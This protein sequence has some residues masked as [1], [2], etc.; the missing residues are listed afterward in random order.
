MGGEQTS[1]K[2]MKRPFATSATLSVCPK[3]AECSLSLLCHRPML[4]LLSADA[5]PW[6]LLA[7]LELGKK[8]LAHLVAVSKLYSLHDSHSSTFL[9]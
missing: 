8:K 6:W 3:A 2:G 5:K 1:D 9:L 4:D 7:R